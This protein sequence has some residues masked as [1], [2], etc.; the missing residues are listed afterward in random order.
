M[1]EISAKS[2]KEKFERKVPIEI[3]L[4]KFQWQKC[5]DIQKFT[6]HVNGFYFEP[7]KTATRPHE[8]ILSRFR[9]ILPGNQGTLGLRVIGARSND[10]RVC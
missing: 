10:P 5:A 7:V 2:L 3:L 4:P 8:G 6:K 1:H 9:I